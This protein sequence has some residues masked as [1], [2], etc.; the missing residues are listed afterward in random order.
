MAG[1]TTLPVDNTADFSV[2]QLGL[3]ESIGAENAEFVTISTV[4]NAT[5]LTVSTTVFPHNRGGAVYLAEYNQIVVEK[6]ATI[7]G[8]YSV[9]GTFNIQA[10]QDRKSTRLNSSHSAKSRMPSSA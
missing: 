1:V 8:V 5:S 10:T 7:D 9:F 3:L 4:P 6:A 2:T